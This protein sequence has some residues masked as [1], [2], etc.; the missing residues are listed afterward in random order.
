MSLASLMSSWMTSAVVM[1][2]EWYRANGERCKTG[3]DGLKVDIRGLGGM[4]VVP[5]SV[6]PTGPYA[7]E[8]YAFFEGGCDDLH[9]LPTS[10][11]GSLHEGQVV[12]DGT[13]NDR[14]F[15]FLLRQAHACDDLHAL[16]T[17]KPGSL[18][19]GQ[20]VYDGTRNDR[21]FKFLLRQAHACDDPDALTDVARS[22]NHTAC[23]PLLSDTEVLKT[24]RSAWRYQTEGRIWAGGPARVVFTAEDHARLDPD[25]FYL[26]AKLKFS[27]GGRREPFAVASEAMERDAVIPGWGRKRYMSA[28]NRLVVERR[29]K[30]TPVEG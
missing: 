29:A 16:P 3:L 21:L 7:G 4:I 9:A 27:H 5:P 25:A 14:L 17:S 19:E 23:L 6:R 28:T 2:L 15:K 10:K 8:R 11:P 30:L 12:Y 20:V 18:H 26:I 1:A 24:A 13:R 22:F